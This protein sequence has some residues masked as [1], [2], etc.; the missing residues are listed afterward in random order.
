VNIVGTFLVIAS[1]DVEDKIQV[2]TFVRLGR[3][4]DKKKIEAIPLK[5]AVIELESY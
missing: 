1:C 3:G 5:P 2:N 4:S